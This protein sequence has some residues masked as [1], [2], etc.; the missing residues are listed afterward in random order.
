M[1]EVGWRF[2]QGGLSSNRGMWRKVFRARR[3]RAL[4]VIP[5]IG[6]K[7][8]QAGELRGFHSP[9][10]AWDGRQTR[11]EFLSAELTVRASLCQ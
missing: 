11:E 2:V 4:P 9:G 8:H 3:F 6:V 1:V 10:S 7:G 5:R